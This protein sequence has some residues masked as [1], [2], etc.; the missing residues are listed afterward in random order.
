MIITIFLKET[1]SVARQVPASP[2]PYPTNPKEQN[3]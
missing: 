1:G 2:A 3:P